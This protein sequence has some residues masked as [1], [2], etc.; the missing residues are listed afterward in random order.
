MVYYNENRDR[1]IKKFMTVRLA[2]NGM[3]KILDMANNFNIKGLDTNLSMS[4]GSGVLTLMEL[5]NAY[6]MIANGG[7]K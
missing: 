5:T 6:A 7:K 2:T 3:E 1:K 4:L